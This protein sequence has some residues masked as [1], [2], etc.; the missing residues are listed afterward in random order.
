MEIPFVGGAY[1]GRVSN[2]NS[3]ECLNLY[4]EMDAQGGK[5]PA[6]LVGTPGMRLWCTTGITGQVRGMLVW[7]DYLYAVVGATLYRISSAAAVVSA[8][9]IGTTTGKVWLA[10]GTTH[11]MVVDGL[12][13]YYQTDGATSLQTIIV[14]G[15]PTL[16]TSL[17]YQDGMF[18]VTEEDSDTFYIS[19]SEDASAWDGMDFAS[20]EDTPDDALA[21]I[22]QNRELWVF[23]EETTE[24]FYNSGDIDFPFTRVAGGV[25]KVGCGAA[26]S[27]AHGPDGIFFLDNGYRVRRVV[28]YQSQVI[29]TPQ[30]E[31][32]IGRY[33]TKS[34][35][36][37]YVYT[38]EGHT[39]YMLT[40]PG[41]SRT[42]CY[43]ATTGAWHMR[44]SGLGGGRH[45]SNCYAWFAGKHLVGDFHTGNIYELALDCYTDDGGTILRRRAAPAVHEDRRLLFHNAL[46]LEF[47][48]GV[49][50]VT[51]QGSDPQAM[52]DWSDDGGHTWSSEHWRSIGK[53]G[54][55]RARAIWRR[56]GRSRDRVY[57]VKISDPIKVVI[58]GAHLEAEGAAA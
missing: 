19:S 2:L 18:I 46:E 40:F 55:Y 33:G 45:R 23:G 58:L 34:D 37:G 13:G 28:G 4:I 54:E 35:A 52:L 12:D 16:P 42:W 56:L 32:Q 47:E 39:F 38:Q 41:A 29:S 25:F 11:L 50:L 43:D 51:G 49:G 21:I 36:V 8:G 7:K 24:V 1:K 44:S 22:N 57:R 53:I 5:T 27:I 3:Q 31:Y 20:A 14:S 30:I 48:A 26:A 17:A 6:A 10:G 9:T 15:F